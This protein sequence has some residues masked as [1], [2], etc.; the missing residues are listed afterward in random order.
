MMLSHWTE[1]VIGYGM[2][3]ESFPQSLRGTSGTMHPTLGHDASV[4]D[5]LK[6]SRYT[7]IMN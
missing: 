1:E 2:E 3:Y 7:S 6:Y 5:N 4:Y